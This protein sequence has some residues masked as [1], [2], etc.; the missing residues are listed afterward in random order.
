M[1][2]RVHRRVY[3]DYIGVKR[4]DA[5]GKLVGEFRIVGLFT[6]TAY[7]RSIALDPV[8]APQGRRRA[9]AA[10]ASIP[11]SHSGKAL[12]N[13]LETY[14]R[15]ELFQIDEDTL[16]HFALA[17]LQLD[18][19]PR[20]RVLARR[21]RFDRFVSVLVY[22]PRE[23]YDSSVRA[24][25]GDY[26]AE[27]FKGRVS[28]FYPFFPEGA[29]GARAFHHRRATA[30]R[31]P[32]PTA[33]RWSTRSTRSCAPGPTSS[34][35]RLPR[36]YEPAQ[37]ARAVATRYRDAFSDGYR[38]AYSPQVAVAD[39][40]VIESAD[41]R[42]GRSASTSIARDGTSK[43]GVGLKVWSYRP[44]DP[45]VGARAGAGEHGLPGRRRA[46]PTTSR[47]HGRTSPTSGCTT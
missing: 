36:R 7:T 22:V 15:D 8:S 39:I 33:R 18:E 24:Q 31:R 47:P 3:L 42:S 37:R 9:R 16:Y 34:P 43:H 35:R 4:F 41:R 30:A 20:V 12:V 19:R 21:D 26:L 44:A 45:A 17:I 40:R 1:R 27:V 11:E 13:V 25:I 28:A 10:P 23:R 32:I 14:P 5:D 46:A 38:E 29:A 6:S 2:S